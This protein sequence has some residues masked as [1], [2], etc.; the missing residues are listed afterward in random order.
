MIQELIDNG[1]FE[2][3]LS[4]LV[5]AKNEEEV[6]QK[7]Q[8]LVALSRNEEAITLAEK[9]LDTFEKF[10]YDIFALYITALIAKGDEDTAI[11]ELK[12]ELSM[13]WVPS[14]YEKMFN[15][16]YDS[17]LK[18]RAQ[19]GKLI[20]Q[21]DLYSDE[22]LAAIINEQT[23]RNLVILALDQLQKRNIRLFLPLL[24]RYLADA[25]RP[26]DIKT[27]IIELLSNQGIDE[28]VKIVSKNNV[29]EVNPS[30]TK[31]LMDYPSIKIILEIIEKKNVDKNTTINEISEELLISYLASIYPID[32]T[33]DEYNL[34]A[35]AI[36]Y[37]ALTNC[38]IDMEVSDI[39]SLFE[40]KEAFL[41]A[42]YDTICSLSVV[43]S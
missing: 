39:C 21:F 34:V 25:N 11:D 33:E 27:M 14:K 32:I 6:Y 23:S 15:E 31:S 36:F 10:Y 30:K 38:C 37:A 22:E 13:P 26:N 3:V 35:A 16:T 1:K 28:D 18:K 2:E 29:I 7:M 8:C 41:L 43:E 9:T 5:V 4:K 24:K 17:L 19:S 12:E 40:V 20:N 42:Y